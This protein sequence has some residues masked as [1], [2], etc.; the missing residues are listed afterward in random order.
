[1]PNIALVCDSTA[2]LQEAELVNLGVEMVPLK[3]HFGTELF[4]DYLDISS[5]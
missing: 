3:V 5:V 2:D 4:R 1:M